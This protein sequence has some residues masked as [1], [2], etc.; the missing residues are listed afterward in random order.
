MVKIEVPQEY[1]YIILIVI[2]SY[3][4]NM[5]LSFRVGK[6]RKKYGVFYPKMYGDSV[7]FNCIQRSHQN[8]LEFYPFFIV[9]LLLGGFPYPVLGAIAGFVY[10]VGRIVYAIGYST[11][12]PSSRFWGSFQYLGLLF[13][14]FSSAKFGFNL[15]GW[16]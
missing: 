3:C 1:G 11:G 6:A 16:W 5:W 9:L 15:L 10:L 8:Y 13:L 7:V 4:V 12:N 14:L 2:L